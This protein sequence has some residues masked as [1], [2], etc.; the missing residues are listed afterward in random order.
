MFL[1]NTQSSSFCPPIVYDLT[2]KIQTTLTLEGSL[3]E[4]AVSAAA[5]DRRGNY[6]ITGSTKVL[7]AYITKLMIFI[8]LREELS[9]TIQKH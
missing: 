4:E 2:S 7:I 6:I 8:F 5:Y 9:Y 3:P 1:I